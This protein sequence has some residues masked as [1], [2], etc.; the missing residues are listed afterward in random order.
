MI[1]IYTSNLLKLRFIEK[2][3]NNKR[4]INATRRSA[5]TSYSRT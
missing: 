3:H 5:S 4:Y 2:K 1:K